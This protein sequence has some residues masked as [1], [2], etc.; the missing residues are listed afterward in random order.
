[1]LICYQLVLI[2]M[3]QEHEQEEAEGSRVESRVDKITGDANGQTRQ[4]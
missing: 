2:T 3:I 1:M 4:R